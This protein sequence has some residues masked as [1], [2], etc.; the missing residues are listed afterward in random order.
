[1]I[2]FIQNTGEFFSSNYFDE[3]FSRKVLEKTG[4]AAE[5]QKTFQKRISGLK[6][7]YFRYKQLLIDGKLRTKDRITEASSKTKYASL[8][9]LPITK[10]RN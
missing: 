4:Y 6:D 1:M 5:D 3:D 2:K 10:M 8:G 7:K 9:Y